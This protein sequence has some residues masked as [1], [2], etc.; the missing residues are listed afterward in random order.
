[1]SANFTCD[2][3]GYNSGSTTQEYTCNDGTLS[4]STPAASECYDDLGC[5]TGYMESSGACVQGC[6]VNV[7]GSSL[8]S[9][10]V[11]DGTVVT[12]DATGYDDSTAGTCSVPSAVS[13]TCGCDD[14]NNYTDSNSDDVCEAPCSLSSGDT[15]LPANVEVLSGTVEYNCSD[16]GDYS[17]TITYDACSNGS[18][19][20]S[21][22]GSCSVALPCSGSDDEDT[23]SVSGDAIHIFTTVGSTTFTCTEA[24][25]AKILVVAGGGSGGTPHG[26]Y[27]AGGGGGGE[28]VYNTSVSLSATSYNIV[29]GDGGDPT[30]SGDAASNGE[31]SEFD[32]IITA[33][34]GGGGAN[35]IN[36]AGDGGTGGGGSSFRNAGGTGSSG[37]N[38]GNGTGSNPFAGGGGAGAGENGEDSSTARGGSGG[39]GVEIFIG[40]TSSTPG[41]GVYYGGGAVGGGSKH[42]S[43]QACSNTASNSSGGLGGGGDLGDPGVDGLGGGGAGGCGASTSGGPVQ[44]GGSGI[45]IVRYTIP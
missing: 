11:A 1:L 24:V 7:T 9:T 20:T 30:G 41:D 42:G 10:T 28:V 16:Y 31:D 3:T 45:V 38:G 8:D 44:S 34:G 12:C 15:G 32:S 18:T 4:P 14:G 22:S 25:T 5:D 43:P 19:L 40:T 29:V 13:A 39:D 6:A 37:F 23:T 2:G 33:S 27:A 17:G 26:D 21:V 35:G 36:Y